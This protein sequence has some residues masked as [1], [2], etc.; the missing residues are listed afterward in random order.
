VELKSRILI[1]GQDFLTVRLVL[2]HFLSSS[3]L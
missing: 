3:L 2:R 1:F